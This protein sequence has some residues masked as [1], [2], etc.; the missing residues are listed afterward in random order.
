MW[1]LDVSLSAAD[2]EHLAPGP[3]VTL[4]FIQTLEQVL[5]AAAD[6]VGSPPPAHLGRSKR[7]LEWMNCGGTDPGPGT[8]APFR[9]RKPPG[10]MPSTRFWSVITRTTDDGS[11]AFGLGWD[12]ADRFTAR[13][14]LLT[15]TLDTAAHR[16]AAQRVLGFVSGDVWEDVRAWVV[17]QGEDTYG[18][19]LADPASLSTVLAALDNEEELQLGEQLL[20][21]EGID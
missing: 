13:M 4:R 19:V 14:R 16:D 17:A 2:Y 3:E 11:G 18:R 15:A 21:L 8:L 6:K 5:T 9:V 12:Q 1:S 10:P 20:Y 7:E